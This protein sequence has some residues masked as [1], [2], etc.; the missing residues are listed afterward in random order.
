[1]RPRRSSV[2]AWTSSTAAAPG[3]CDETTDPNRRVDNAAAV[4][5]D[6][7]SGEILAMVGSPDYFDPRIQG[8]VNAAL[9]LR[10]PGSAIKP[11]TY[12]AALDPRLERSGRRNSIDPGVDHRR[13]AHHLLR[14]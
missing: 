2:V 10:Q 6:S 9:S 1:M 8:N 12:A 11:L 5:L 13:S 14:D 3:I 7:A 4:V